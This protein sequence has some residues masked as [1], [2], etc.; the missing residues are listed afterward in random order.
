M[1]GS[2]GGGVG[3]EELVQLVARAGGEM[4]EEE[5]RALVRRADRDG[6]GVVSYQAD[7]TAPVFSG[8]AKTQTIFGVQISNVQCRTFR[9]VQGTENCLISGPGVP[10]SV[11]RVGGRGGVRGPSG[12]QGSSQL[13][14]FNQRRYIGLVGESD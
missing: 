13:L 7:K 3:S 14:P 1:A 10:Q 11:G 12:V 6:D 4:E 8:A 5:A 9:Q 2:S